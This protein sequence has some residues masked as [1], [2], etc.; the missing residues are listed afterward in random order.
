MELSDCN[1]TID[2]VCLQNKTLEECISEYSGQ[3]GAGVYF[4]FS[5]KFS[6]IIR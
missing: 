5:I 3:C 1:D 2:G 4:K 6:H